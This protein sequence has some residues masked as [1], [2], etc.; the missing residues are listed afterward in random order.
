MPRFFKGIEEKP[1]SFQYN[2]IVEVRKGSR[3]YKA[4]VIGGILLVVILFLIL[5][6]FFH[7]S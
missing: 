5:N 7:S 2:T 6:M 4:W 3:N 1:K